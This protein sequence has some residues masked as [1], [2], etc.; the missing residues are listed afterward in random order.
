MGKFYELLEE[1]LFMIFIFPLLMY[2]T[3]LVIVALSFDYINMDSF[4]LIFIDL[5]MCKKV[6]TP[7]LV[8]LQHGIYFHVCKKAICFDGI[9]LLIGDMLR[10]SCTLFI[11]PTLVANCLPTNCLE[12]T[13]YN[14]FL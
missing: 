1:L 12:S 2:R 4:A 11:V 8:M 5:M 14:F 10:S 7:P 3:L 9:G 13:A 6:I